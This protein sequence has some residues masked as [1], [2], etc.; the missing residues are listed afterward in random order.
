[1]MRTKYTPTAPA[2]PQVISHRT[3]ASYVTAVLKDLRRPA[4]SDSP[5]SAGDASDDGYN[6]DD[7]GDDDDDDD[8][9]DS[10]SSGDDNNKGSNKTKL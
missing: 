1:M 4:T 5:A 2:N 7:N 9:G 3:A 8:D 10:S 6:D